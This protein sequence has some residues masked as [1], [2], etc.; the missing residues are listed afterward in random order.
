MAKS[1]FCCATFF[2][3]LICFLLLL[4][5]EMPMAEATFCKRPAKYLSGYCY[6]DRCYNY[7]KY[8]EHA[9]SGKCIWT[10]AG[11]HDHHHKHLACYCF[12]K[13]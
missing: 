5:N 4:P 9:Y 10:W 12:Y 13:C 11:D 8:T 2:A 7:C 3:L 1:Q 6:P